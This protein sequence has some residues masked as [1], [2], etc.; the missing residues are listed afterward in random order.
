MILNTMDNINTIMDVMTR[1]N[2]HMTTETLTPSVVYDT[3]D[4][5]Y[6]HT[7]SDTL[8]GIYLFIGFLGLLGNT[9]V[10]IVIF[11]SKVMR[12]HRTNIYIVNQCFID[13]TVALFLILTTLLENDGRFFQED[14]IGDVLLC[15]LWLT[16][17]WLW[18]FLVSSSY[19][20]MALT[21][22]RYLAIVHPFVH[23][24]KIT[25]PKLVA[26]LIVVWLVGPLYNMAYMIPS[27]AVKPDGNCSVYSEWPSHRVQ[28][29]VGIITIIIQFVIPIIFL[30]VCYTLIALNL[31]RRLTPQRPRDP[32]SA[33]NLISST[34]NNEI[35]NKNISSALRNIIRTV[36]I[37]S[38]CFMFC[39]T[40]NQVYFLMFHLN[41]QI[42]MSFSSSF[43]HFT[44]VMVFCNCC[45][46]PFIYIAQYKAFQRATKNLFCR[47]NRNLWGSHSSDNT[48]I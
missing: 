31:R 12:I 28:N 22:E 27:S 40:W 43:Y 1:D 39:W 25:R 6:I 16:K 38:V 34:R 17:L 47:T 24:V 36:F 44:V 7:T 20:L 15:K 45:I 13:A 11:S 46:N 33:G 3:A 37:V 26:S 19:N 21:F 5:N 9:F 29:L 48:P 10:I 35:H 42:A 2:V 14:D 4:K 18:S 23:K 30:I 41:F 32:H 8:R